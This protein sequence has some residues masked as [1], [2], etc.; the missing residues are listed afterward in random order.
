VLRGNKFSLNEVPIESTFYKTGSTSKDDYIEKNPLKIIFDLH[1]PEKSIF[2]WEHYFDIY[3]RHLSKF[4]NKKPVVLEIGV[5]GGG[6]LEMWR[7]YFGQGCQILGVD[8]DP[9][10]KAHESEDITIFIGDQSNPKFWDDFNKKV[11]YVD[12]IIDDGG[13]KS[14]QQIVTI[15]KL[16]HR[17]NRGGVYL[18]E[19]IIGENNYF[20][21]YLFGMANNLNYDSGH[22]QLGKKPIRFQQQIK[23]FHFYPFVAI[24]EVNEKPVNKLVTI[25]TKKQKSP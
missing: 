5:L 8:I 6:S 17:L 7:E 14:E 15:E 23:S 24:I 18:C 9:A 13:H 19:D 11:P 10:C 25:K 12:V 2:K 21:P 4:I 16:F 20:M 22:S 3:H 1:S